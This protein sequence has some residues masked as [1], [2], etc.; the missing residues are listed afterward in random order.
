MN[1]K[2]LEELAEALATYP[3][4]GLVTF[5]VYPLVAPEVPEKII[6]AAMAQL[7]KK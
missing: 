5:K 2:S 6:E 3:A 4:A 7:P 1:V